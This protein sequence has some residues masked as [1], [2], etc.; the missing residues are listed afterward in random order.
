MEEWNEFEHT[1]FSTSKPRDGFFTDK[2][3][4]NTDYTCYL[5][6]VAGKA[7]SRP[8]SQVEFTTAPGSKLLQ[9]F[10]G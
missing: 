4:P 2:L 3:L 10:A 5:V 7:N 8:T 6:S 1:A 9:R